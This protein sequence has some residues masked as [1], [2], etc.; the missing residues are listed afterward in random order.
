MNVFIYVF[1][2]ATIQCTSAQYDPLMIEN[3]QSG[4]LNSDLVLNFID[5]LAGQFDFSSFLT[6]NN[7]FDLNYLLQQFGDIPQ[8]L[9]DYFTNGNFDIF[10]FSN[11][12][13][14]IS[15]PCMNKTIDFIQALRA[16][17]EWALQSLFFNFKYK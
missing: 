12:L 14:N 8:V 13:Q 2:L 16:G 11:Q 1:F 10:D 6:S 7:S 15:E 4:I 5:Q 17:E 3:L 9:S